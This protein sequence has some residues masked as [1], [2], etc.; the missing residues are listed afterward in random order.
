MLRSQSRHGGDVTSSAHERPHGPHAATGDSTPGDTGPPPTVCATH[1][2]PDDYGSY[3]PTGVLVYWTW[4][5]CDDGKTYVLACSSEATKDP[6]NCG[7]STGPKGG[8]LANGYD[9]YDLP[10]PIGYA[11]SPEALLAEVCGIEVAP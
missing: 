11:P 3:E 10:S 2:G 8:T 1:L 9:T 4:D 5:D 7:C 6:W